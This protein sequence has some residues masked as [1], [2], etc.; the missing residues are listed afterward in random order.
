[1]PNVQSCLRSL[2]P[3]RRNCIFEDETLNLTLHKEYSQTN[4]FLECSLRTAQEQL[5]LKNNKSCSPWFFPTNKSSS[6]VCDPWESLDFLTEMYDTPDDNCNYC[7]PSCS[8]TIYQPSVTA[9][10]F[11][12]CDDSNMGVTD[13]CNL[14]DK[15]IPEPK[16]WARQVRDHR[17]TLRDGV[18]P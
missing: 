2:P 3:W 7:L 4:C 5:Q 9:L 6:A 10:P 13:L 17:C 16:M 1:M 15:T 12:R 11:R 18:K 14:D 8:Y